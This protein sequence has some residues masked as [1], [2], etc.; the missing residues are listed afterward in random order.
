MSFLDK[1]SNDLTCQ[2][3]EILN[4]SCGPHKP[5]CHQF[6]RDVMVF[7]PGISALA[8]LLVLLPLDASTLGIRKRDD[9]ERLIP[10]LEE[11]QND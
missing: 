8:I 2:I 6:Y 1:F 4:P 7:I 3:V 5:G 10:A 11:S 9:T